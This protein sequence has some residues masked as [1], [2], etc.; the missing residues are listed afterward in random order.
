[1]AGY[2]GADTLS[3]GLAFRWKDGELET[4]QPLPGAVNS[5][6]YGINSQGIAVG[7][8]RYESSQAPTIMAQPVFWGPDGAPVRPT[9]PD[10]YIGGGCWDISDSN[11]ILGFVTKLNPNGTTTSRQVVWTGGQPH[12][13]S[14]S[15][16]PVAGASFASS[17]AKSM[18]PAGHIVGTG[19]YPGTTG[20]GW[21][22]T[23]QAPPEDLDGSCSV[24]GADLAA[25][26]AQWGPVTPATSAD[27]N[28]DG[29]VD[30]TDMGI[31]LGAW[32]TGP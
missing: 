31:L 24:D 3:T 9:I 20:G 13:L 23:P 22:L 4:L 32:T 28:L 7:M 30:G 5:L 27:F 26:L 25:L 21:L 12:L 19:S 8:C 15:I 1:M 10:G 29:R 14:Q 17:S 11:V 16:L 6:A 18:S 2:L